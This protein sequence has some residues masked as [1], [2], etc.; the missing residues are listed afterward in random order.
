MARKP[1]AKACICCTPMFLPQDMHVAAAMQ[2]VAVD[3]ANHPSPE[4]LRSLGASI[5]APTPDE[6][7]IVTSKYWGKKGKS[8]TVKFME[9][10]QQAL[11]DKILAHM[12]LWSDYANVGFSETAD[13]GADVRVTLDGEGYWSYVGTDILKVPK[14]KPTMC[15]Q[16][17][18]LNH[19][20]SE[21]RRVV[22]HEA[23]HTLGCPHEHMRKEIVQLLDENKV[24][25]Y[26]ADACGWSATKTRQ[27][28]LTPLGASSIMSSPETDRTSIMCYQIPGELT[29]NGQTV[30]GGTELDAVDKRFIGEK[31]PK[32]GGVNPTPPAPPP[33]PS[34]PGGG[35]APDI[36]RD[37]AVG[38]EAAK[39]RAENA[40]LRGQIATLKETI[41]ILSAGG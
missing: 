1:A 27:Q 23:G 39:L 4:A 5:D 26:Y 29:K 3:R 15:L 34:N 11:R 14:S 25:Q 41:R 32:V 35:G 21:F 17:F 9:K 20:D 31:Y 10:Q 30:P 19:P 40:K 33:V 2:A 37:N 24:I 8:F 12:N 7:A 28:V 38:D 16:D 6:L 13:S 22:T 18:S 36:V